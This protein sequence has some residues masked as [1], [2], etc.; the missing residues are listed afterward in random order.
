MPEKRSRIKIVVYISLVLSLLAASGALL[1]PRLLDLDTYRKQILTE[2]QQS[3]KRPVTYAS[4]TFTISYGPAISFSNVV[5]KEP[6]GSSNFVTIDKLTC[7]IALLPLLKKHVVIRGLQAEKPLIWLERKQDGRFNFSDLLEQDASTPP[8]SIKQIKIRNGTVRFKDMLASASGVVTKIE[9]TELHLSSISRGEKSDVKLSGTITEGGSGSFSIGGKVRLAPKDK[10]LSESELDMKIE[11]KQLD[12]GHF[13][14]YYSS[15]VPFGKILGRVDAHTSF[16]GRVREFSSTGK[17]SFSGLR[18]DY[19][20]VFRSALTPTSLQLKYSMELTSKDVLVKALELAI[21][22]VDIKGSCAIRD[23]TTKDPRITAQAITSSFDFEKCHQ[24]IPYGI[25]VKDTSDWIE[26]HIKGGIYRLDDGRLDGRVSQIVHMEKGDNY[27]VLYIKGRVEKGVISYG[28]TVPTFNSIKGVLEMKGKDFLLHQMSGRF[29]TAP[30]TL[31]GRIT[32]YPLVTPCAYPFKMTISPGQEELAWLLGKARG[33]RLF[34]NGN[35]L[36]NLSGEGFTSGYRLA[37]AWNLTPAAY[38]YT[39]MVTKPVGI[40]SSLNF[41]LDLTPKDA[42]VSAL[43]YTLGPMALDITA[44]YP[45]ST[46]NRLDLLINSNLFNIGEIAGMIPPI[47]KYQPS[48][49]IQLS[50]RGDTADV[51]KADFKWRGALSMINASVKP[52][53]NSKLV[54]AINGRI[55]FEDTAMES[56][57]L[58]ARFG[59][60]TF[61]GKVSIANLTPLAF[62]TS[63]NA[64]SVDL[65]DFGIAQT[66][67]LQISRVRA[68][69]AFNDNNL[70]IKN[71]SGQVNSSQLDIKGS[72]TDIND[73][74]IDLMV[75]SPALDIS[76]I[77]TLS[78]LEKKHQPGDKGARPVTLKASI[79]ADSGTFRGIHFE[80]LNTTVQVANKIVYLQPLEAALFGGRLT[81]K[82]RIDTLSAQNRYQVEFKLAGASGV[83]IMQQL[84]LERELT[85]TMTV[86]GELTT[87]GESAEELKK[88]ALGSIKIAARNGSLR[89]FPTLSKVFSILNVSQLFKLKLPDMVSEGMPYNGIKATLSF[90]DGTLSTNDLFVTSNAMNMSFVGSYNYIHDNMNFTLGIQPLQTVDKV[91]SH[92]PIV[93]WILTGKDKTLLTTYFEI[94]GK[95]SDPQVSAIPV[96]YLAKGVFDI[97]KR[98]FQL[99]AKLVTDT[100]E[101]I[102][103]N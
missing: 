49:R 51:G 67:P 40:P 88:S 11:T 22:G 80:K 58:T 84:S 28:S 18:F 73:P 37:G 75:H 81:A 20:P 34:Y 19:Q 38:T 14:P 66:K 32:D 8:L 91:V 52:T 72:I 94:K 33:S 69:L 5:I 96:K 16:N 74:K 63:F 83:Q 92:I 71:L 76:D 101:V 65:S 77:L 86:E 39:S 90:K 102:L 15:Y 97:F 23:I 3:L 30:F 103:G 17:I 43:H 89:Q 24:Y 36:L 60:S 6:D 54:S 50:L 1:L 46:G 27:N 53:E 56:S 95:T 70:Q 98:V 26:Q 93:G 64:P 2:L 99:P 61:N 35:G 12:V 48:G 25:I 79:M 4:G 87:K 45:F 68:D 44:Q 31:E 13:W 55:S 85:G 78:E 62:N 7:Q 100:G 82:G 59:N 57:Q 29:G 10:P 9:S 21:D 47:N 41:R 42:T